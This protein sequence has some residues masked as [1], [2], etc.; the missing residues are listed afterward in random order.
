MGQQD[1]RRVPRGE[2]KAKGR[3]MQEVGHRYISPLQ[4]WSLLSSAW[5]VTPAR[6]GGWWQLTVAESTEHVCVGCE[7]C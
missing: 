2:G 5:E 3:E 1:S 4:P 6:G 7:S